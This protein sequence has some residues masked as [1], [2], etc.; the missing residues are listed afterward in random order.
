M[1]DEVSAMAF[2]VFQSSRTLHTTQQVCAEETAST[3]IPLD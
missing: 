2:E 1:A 3:L